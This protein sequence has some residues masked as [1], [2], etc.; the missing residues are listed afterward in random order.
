MTSPSVKR[1]LRILADH[2]LAGT[3]P[4][5]PGDPTLYFRVDTPL[6]AIADALGIY[7]YVEI[8]RWELEQRQH[9]N[10]AAFPSAYRKI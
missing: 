3:K 5:A 10:R 1:Y 4:G 8:K 2:G 7:G 9:A 6:D